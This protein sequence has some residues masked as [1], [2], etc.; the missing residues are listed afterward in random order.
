MPNAL[1]LLIIIFYS[2]YGISQW[3]KLTQ[4]A[5][6][7]KKNKEDLLNIRSCFSSSNSM[8]FLRAASSFLSSVGIGFPSENSKRKMNIT[9]FVIPCVNKP[10]QRVHK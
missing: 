5:L 7:L 9:F 4:M 1:H 8:A 3:C 6:T 10:V 2:A